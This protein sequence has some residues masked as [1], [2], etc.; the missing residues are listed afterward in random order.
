MGERSLKARLEAA[1]IAPEYEDTFGRVHETEPE[2]AEALLA[3]MGLDEELVA[4]PVTDEAVIVTRPERRTPAPSGRLV[5]EDGEVRAVEER[6]PP[7]LPLGYHTLRRDDG[8]TTQVIVSPGGCV[9]PP[10][11]VWGWSLQLY[12][13]LSGGSWGVGDLADL[14]AVGRW[15][16]A[17]GASLVLVNPL[18][19]V[20]AAH[21]RGASP[22]YPSSR[23]FLDPLYLRIDEVPGAASSAAALGPL[24][25]E[26]RAGTDRIDR[27]TVIGAKYRALEEIWNGDDGAGREDDFVRYRHERGAALERFATFEAL[28]EVHGA[29]WRSWPTRYR[30]P[31]SDAVAGFA[32]EHA[33]RVSFHAWLQ[34]LLDDQLRAASAAVPVVRDLPIGFDPDGADAWEWQGVL[35]EGVTVGAP[36]DELGPSG[37]DWGLPAFVPWKLR[38]AGYRPFIETL[39]AAFRHA[40]ALRIDHVLGLFRLYWTTE[41]GPTAGSYVRQHEEALLD[42]L[43]LESH[44]AGA[45]VIGEDLGTVGEGVREELAERH[46]L[47]YR[48]FWF[49]ASPPDAWDEQAV[50]ALTTHDLPSIGGLWTGAE[51]ELHEQLGLEVDE[52]RLG[53]MRD[54]LARAAGID[55]DADTQEACVAAARML[56]GASSHVTLMQLEDAVGA[57]YRINVP[58]TDAEVRPENWSLPLPCPLEALSDHPTVSRVVAVMR[59]RRPT[60]T[61]HD[62]EVSQ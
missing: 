53:R 41:A 43:A 13:L 62:D 42:I 37:Q 26:A 44:R 6:L 56:A 47:G 5:L 12:S 36:P 55:P 45:W 33:D 30:D 46:I 8:D 49:E 57:T 7:G 28:T 15:S 39:R 14:R 50:G 25:A 16:R 35:A 2:T 9:P 54:G 18:D 22:Y 40:A 48:V 58:G 52:E 38:A 24:A 59:E 4:P 21:P 23:R 32:V 51:L 1:G 29:G 3:A 27:D 10:T 17:A 19:A 11:D 20:V 34:W 31:A 60:A 61:N